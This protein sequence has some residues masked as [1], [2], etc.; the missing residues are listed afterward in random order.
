MEK[1]YEIKLITKHWECTDKNVYKLMSKKSSQ[2]KLNIIKLGCLCRE[3]NISLEDLKNVAEI[4][5][6][7][8]AINGNR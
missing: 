4:I 3:N 5:K 2:S 8:K 1:A 6:L 7:S